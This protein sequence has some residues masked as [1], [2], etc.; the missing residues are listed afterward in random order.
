MPNSANDVTTGLK[1]IRYYDNLNLA[2]ERGR[3]LDVEATPSFIVNLIH[4]K[5][6]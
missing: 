4:I 2:N 3:K 5:E 6:N 1:P